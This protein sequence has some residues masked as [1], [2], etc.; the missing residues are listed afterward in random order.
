M[1]SAALNPNPRKYDCK[2]EP[3]NKM[4]TIDTYTHRYKKKFQSNLEKKVSESF[5]KKFSIFF[6]EKVVKL[7]RKKKVSRNNP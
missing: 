5:L 2:R 3:Q 1:Q 4:N 7:S 6:R